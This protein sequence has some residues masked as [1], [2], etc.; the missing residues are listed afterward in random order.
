MIPQLNQLLH[1][2]D[3]SVNE[4]GTRSIT[5]PQPF[6][7]RLVEGD[8]RTYETQGTDITY[9]ASLHT[10]TELELKTGDVVKLIKTGQDVYY[11]VAKVVATR[12]LDG[13][14]L[15]QWAE[16]QIEKSIV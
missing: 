9:N 1:R 16:L 13:E 7:G 10:N 8:G 12:D 4:Y 6:M 14:I 11:T 2:Y 15:F 5:N 3:T